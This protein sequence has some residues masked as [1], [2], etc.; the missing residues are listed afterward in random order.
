MNN[1][2][3]GTIVEFVKTR[4]V[5]PIDTI[6]LP[7]SAFLTLIRAVETLEERVRELERHLTT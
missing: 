1:S 2:A 5:Y 6:S 3:I 7:S 4:T